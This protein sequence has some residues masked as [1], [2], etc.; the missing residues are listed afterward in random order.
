MATNANTGGKDLVRVYLEEIGHRPLLTAGAEC[1]LARQIHAGE[2]ARRRLEDEE[3]T[4]GEAEELRRLAR[5]GDQAARRFT[6]TNLRLVVAIA[7]RY[8]WSGM[9]LLDLIQEGNLGLMK[10][11]RRFDGTKG[12]RFSTY[13][14][15]WIRQSILRG[16]RDGGRSIRLPDHVVNRAAALRR[17]GDDL[18]AALGR[19]ATTEELAATL[20]WTT[21]Q[22]EE[23]AAVPSQPAS[24]DEPLSDDSA[25][26]LA[27]Q[28][29]DRE[30]PDVA[31]QATARLTP[32]VLE[33]L[34]ANVSERERLVLG[35]RFGLGDTEPKTLVAVA[36]VLGTSRERVRQ[37]ERRALVKLRSC[38]QEE[39]LELVAS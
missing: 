8:Q 21:E 14:T 4:D 30:A 35:M 6:E 32:E 13:A 11:V 7:K 28:V 33:R 25:E 27:T 22:V 9:P 37:I 34:L 20:G 3:L 12:Y 5:A 16:I 31:Q 26:S 39:E 17:A 1:D 19:T 23:V 10:A 18:R 2:A 38:M 36:G 29:S 24:L 15:W